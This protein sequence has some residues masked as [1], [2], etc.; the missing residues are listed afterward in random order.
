MKFTNSQERLIFL[1]GMGLTRGDICR[2]LKWKYDKVCRI[3]AQV[4]HKCL[5]VAD[6]MYSNI[7]GRNE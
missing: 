4:R 7:R 3:E 1:K 6:L 5:K 2:N